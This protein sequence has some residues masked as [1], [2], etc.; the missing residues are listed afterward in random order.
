LNLE[1]LQR[2]T[3]ATLPLHFRQIA[4]WVVITL[5]VG[6][7]TGLIFTYH[8]T[9]LTPKGVQERYRGNQPESALVGNDSAAGSG[10]I[11]DTATFDTMSVASGNQGI[12][13][14]EEQE[15]KFE[16][17]L[18]EML[19]ITHTHI[20]AMATF[21]AFTAIIFSLSTTLG[22]RWKSFLIVEP[23]VAIV[24]SFAAMWLMRYV[25]PGFSYL[26]MLSSGSMAL[27]F[28]VMNA[29]SFVELIRR[30]REG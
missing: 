2:P 9:S 20:L 23:F 6:Y 14:G 28:Y 12:E 5:T 13:G 1:A 3:L 18:A 21:I 29:I 15:M 7:T 27:C 17:S 4:L 16:K 25:H 22:T 10:M 11:A 24:T 26:L 8:T 19:N 30:R